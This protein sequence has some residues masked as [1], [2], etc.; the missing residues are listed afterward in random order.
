[1]HKINTCAA[2]ASEIYTCAA[3]ANITTIFYLAL[4]LNTLTN[5]IAGIP[6]LKLIIDKR[7]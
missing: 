2:N 5:L 6:L 3:N 1:M 4:F 7:N